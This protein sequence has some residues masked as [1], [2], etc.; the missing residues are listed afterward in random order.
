[1]TRI[2]WSS[3]DPSLAAFTKGSHQIRF[4]GTLVP[5]HYES[6][7]QPFLADEVEQDGSM[8][9]VQPNATGRSWSPEAIRLVGAVDRVVT[10][11][12]D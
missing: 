7:A 4:T 3:L 5:D 2:V 10:I 6:V 9:G 8:L 12:E 11:V 1:M